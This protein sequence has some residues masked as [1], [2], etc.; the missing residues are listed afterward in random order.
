MSNSQY[1]QA[2]HTKVLIK[3]KTN[4]PVQTQMAHCRIEAS[5]L[6]HISVWSVRLKSIV[7]QWSSVQ[8]ALTDLKENGMLKWL[9]SIFCYKLCM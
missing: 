4:K 1:Q 9:R 8:Y 6:S 7:K 3:G 5:M 2:D